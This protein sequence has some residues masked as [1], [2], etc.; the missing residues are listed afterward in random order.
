VD[1]PVARAAAAHVRRL[2]EG[3]SLI[4]ASLL[5]AEADE[6]RIWGLEV[7]I[8]SK[9]REAENPRVEVQASLSVGGDARD[10]MYAVQPHLQ[11]DYLSF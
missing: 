4:R 3:N 8:A 5:V 10:V 2:D 7:R 1:H 11:F 9:E 6:M